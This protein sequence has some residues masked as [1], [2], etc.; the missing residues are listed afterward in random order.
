MWKGDHG[1]G[2]IKKQHNLEVRKQYAHHLQAH[3]CYANQQPLEDRSS[4]CPRF[5]SLCFQECLPLDVLA[6][7]QLAATIL[8]ILGTALDSSFGLWF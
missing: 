6:P 3:T 7:P 4:P 1:S 2:M 5:H 8:V